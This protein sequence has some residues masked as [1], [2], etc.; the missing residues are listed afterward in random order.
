M[1][2]PISI[3][4]QW[5][6]NVTGLQVIFADDDEPAA[7]RPTANPAVLTYAAIGID[8]DQSEYSTAHQVTE[9][10]GSVVTQYRSQVRSGTL[11]V[12]FYGPGADDYARA[13][14]LSRCHQATN[15]LLATWGDVSLGASSQVADTPRLRSA[16]REPGASIAIEITWV[17]TLATVLT[18][19][20]ESAVSTVDVEDPS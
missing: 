19:Y 6:V 4:R 18:Q 14:D 3:L 17:D 11:S 20:A 8:S 15:D 10:V 7:P 16:E 9:K 1:P 13:L 2:S 12:E 5:I